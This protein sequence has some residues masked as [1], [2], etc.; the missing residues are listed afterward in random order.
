VLTESQENTQFLALAMINIFDEVKNSW[1][2]SLSSF[3]K[4]HKINFDDPSPLDPPAPL[5]RKFPK[6]IGDRSHYVSSQR[7][8]GVWKCSQL[9]T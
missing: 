9:L 5:K 3:R 2:L 8:E 7:E 4:H 1:Y 6:S